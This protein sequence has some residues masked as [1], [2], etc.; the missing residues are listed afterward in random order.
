MAQE[1]YEPL[2]EYVKTFRDR[3]HDITRATFDSISKEANVDV[4]AN[5][6]TCSLLYA[7][8]KAIDTLDAQMRYWKRLRNVLWIAVAVGAYFAWSEYIEEAWGWFSVLCIGIIIAVVIDRRRICP[9]IKDIEGKSKRQ[10]KV[11]SKLKEEAWKQMEP[12][13]RLYDWDIFARMLAKAVP[14]IELDPYFTEQRQADL[15]VTYGLGLYGYIHNDCSVVYSLSGLINGNPFVICQTKNMYMDMKTYTGEKTIHWTTYE[16]NSDGTS[17]AVEHTETLRATY[18]APY[19]CFYENT[20]LIYGNTAAPDLVFNR[21]KSGLAGREDSRAFK[22]H[23]HELRKKAEDLTHSDYTILNEEFETAFDT[24]D[25]NSNQQFALLFTP[26]A[27]ESMMRLLRDKEYGYGDDFDFNKYHMINTI[28][29]DHLQSINLDMNPD[30]YKGFDYDKAE[31]DFFFFFEEYFRAIYFA[32]APLFCVPMYQ[33]IRPRKAIYG[34]D[35]PTH[36]SYWELEALANFWGDNCFKHPACVTD[37]I[38]KTEEQREGD[39]A[40][41]TVSAYGFR[42]EP[43]VSY[44]QVQGG[45]GRT[46]SVPV[47]WDEY[48]PVTGTGQMRIHEDNTFSNDQAL[49]PRERQHHIQEVLSSKNMAVYRRH[50]ASSI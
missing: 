44:V 13:N 40:V 19:P 11:A 43:R 17:R 48:F 38:L 39:D 9:A 14:Q 32:V 26:L 23:L 20:R 16:R 1:I 47:S 10:D 31:K 41:V 6:K 21:R 49:S 2:T 33:Q 46:H 18:S 7:A 30:H 34:L 12:L 37:C 4:E 25:R 50:I 5:R 24:S 22:S 42:S 27:Q 3:F 8:T 45:D 35:M 28:I 36:C 15:A 29:P